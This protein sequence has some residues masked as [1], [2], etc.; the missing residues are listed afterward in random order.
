MGLVRSGRW[1][2]RA[3]LRAGL[4]ASTALLASAVSAQAQ[5]AWTG[6]TSTDWF[7][8]TNWSTNAVPA[9]G[10][11][12]TIDTT[13]PNAPVI[14]GAT[15]PSGGGDYP[16]IFVGDSGTG[17]LTIQNAATINLQSAFIGNNAGSTGTV[18]VTD[19]GSKW[20]STDTSNGTIVGFNGIGTFNALGG[21]IST[22]NTIVGF[23][24]SS[25]GNVT[26]DGAATWSQTGAAP[27]SALFVGYGGTGSFAVQSGGT[28]NAV[29]TY[30]G[31]LAGSNGAVTVTDPGS[32]W[33]SSGSIFVG[34]FGTGTFNLLGGT[35]T[36]TLDTILGYNAGSTGT[37]N[38]D[39]A[40]ATFP[41]W[42]A[43]RDI[44]IGGNGN[45]QPGGTGIF[46]VRNGGVVNANHDT[47]ISASSGATGTVTVRDANS[48][49]LAANNIFIGGVGTGTFNVLNAG[50]VTASAD[51]SLGTFAG[52]SGTLNVDGTNSKWTSVAGTFFFVGD[53]GTGEVKITNGGLVV[54]NFG[55]VGNNNGAI[56]TVT[57]DGAGSEWRLNGD[58]VVGG[59]DGS[60]S[61]GTGTVN[62]KNSGTFTTNGD[63]F[64]GNSSGGSGNGTVNVDSAG[65]ASV[66]NAH[67]GVY[68]GETG[69]GTLNITNGGV[70]NV[71][72]A[73]FVGDCSCSNGTVTVS[74]AGSQFNSTTIFG[75]VGIGLGGAGTFR[76]LNGGAATFA[77]DVNVGNGIGTGTLEVSGGGFFTTA[78]GLILGPSNGATVTVSGIG[79][80]LTVGTAT[81][82]GN[83]G[84]GDSTLN[85]LNGA[86]ADLG[87]IRV[88]NGGATGTL[89]IDAASSVTGAGYRQSGTGTFNVGLAPT[90]NGKV[91]ITGGDIDL[92]SAGALVV[93]AKTTVAKK[94][95]IM[96]TNVGAV[97][98]T[99]SNV[100]VVGNA[101][102]LQ[103]AY[104]AP[105]GAGSCVELSVDTFS[106]ANVLPPG[107]GGN[108][109]NV[110]GAIDK[111]IA[112]GLTIPDP[113]FN[114]FA[115]TGDSL[116]N[117]LSQ[118]SGEPATGAAQSN[119]Q[120]MNSFLS[121]VLNPFG[122]APVG[123]PGTLNYAREFGPTVGQ[124]SPQAAAAYAA[125]T[126]ND[127][128]SN[129]FA[130]HWGIWGQAYGGYNKT[131]GN[132]TA[133]SHDTTAHTYGLAT[134]FDYRAAPD[135]TVGFALAGAGESWG[136]AD[137]LGGGRADAFQLG[138][139]GSKQFDAAYVSGAVAY[140]VHNVTTDRTVTVA[141][142]DHLTAN[143]T[144]QSIGG[145]IETGYRLDTAYLGVTPYAAAQVQ[146][147]F[148][149]NYSE[150]A[151]S[152]SNVFALS[153]QSQSTVASRTELGAWLDKTVMLDNGNR[154]GLRGRLA[155][156]NDQSDN[157]GINAAFQTLPG[158]NFTVTG[159][160]PST[161]LALLTAGAEYWL[162]NN[163]SVG[164][165]F[166]GEFG[167]RSQTYAGT[168]TVRY[169]W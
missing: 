85:V 103:V 93:N 87:L 142:S 51:T 58:S 67:G 65:G 165:K 49:W 159:A 105:C 164:G 84:F 94:Y 133:G 110:A 75:V 1:K 11:Q 128:R 62:V 2:A 134:G 167:S 135:T 145:R 88:G 123:N 96:T 119:T 111:A 107:T 140:A 148:T 143:F 166:D 56:G 36:S 147:F 27:L 23:G 137:G 138:A 154:L 102:N 115:L 163:V 8:G 125:V 106:L 32:S 72:G 12:P 116:V 82:I 132:A 126:P 22:A 150:N 45:S 59:N 162:P 131:D 24:A 155:W 97:L 47:V 30:V 3:P 48:Q 157:K 46:N 6:A 168:A 98:G 19:A 50:S 114:V 122:G 92:T 63:L 89:K 108:A 80:S 127:R 33:S 69:T 158:A 61:A 54:N 21:A 113:F 73:V 153:F 5:Q 160:T 112:S 152:G 44:V 121:L 9:G 66:W 7:T 31:H 81:V 17:S 28:V 77:T 13:T 156:A 83:G 64:L 60:A 68:V 39:G 139:Y 42:T 100:S 14:N 101:N 43:N 130:A 38:V 136:V 35:A 169:A 120:L 40:G 78:G 53:S 4:L 37:I 29:D 20:N 70:V 161:N 149:P 91:A 41:T 26:V 55:F 124:I 104:N 118:L 146:D 76:V 71:D 144:A 99:F 90:S 52:S 18:T 57:I 16:Q 25:S 34:N 79:S 151:V 129:P 15:A 109:A 86:T 117:A 74:G 141:G 95:D 10:D